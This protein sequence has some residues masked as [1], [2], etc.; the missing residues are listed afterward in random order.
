MYINDDPGLTLTYFTARSSLVKIANCAY[1]LNLWL[2]VPNNLS[3]N[4]QRLRSKTNCHR[5]RLSESSQHRG[6]S[7]GITCVVDRDVT[8]YMVF[9]RV[10]RLT[11]E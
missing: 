6:N 5:Y 9:D 2:F 8:A 11:T 1:I 4:L 3:I 10:I 7:K